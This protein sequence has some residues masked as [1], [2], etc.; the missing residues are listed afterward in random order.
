[1]SKKK[2]LT[3]INNLASD[4]IL[5]IKAILEALSDIEQNCYPSNVLLEIAKEKVKN[6]FYNIEKNK[7]ILK[8]ID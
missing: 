7:K 4:K 5:Q 8:I 1:M 3:K 2:K 6:V